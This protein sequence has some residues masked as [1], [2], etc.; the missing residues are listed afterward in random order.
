VLARVEAQKL[1]LRREPRRH[2]HQVLEQ[3]GDLDEVAHAA[4]RGRRLGHEVAGLDPAPGALDGGAG[5][6]VVP[7]VA[8]VP[9][10]P[11]AHGGYQASS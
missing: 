7:H 11:G 2:G 10:E 9:D 8:L 5:P 1:L 6:G 4:L 3:A